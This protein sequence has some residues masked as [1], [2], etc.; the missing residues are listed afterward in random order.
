MNKLTFLELMRTPDKI[1]DVDFVELET[2]VKANPYFQNG[3]CVLA[4]A[5]RKLKKPS[6][7]KLMSSAAIYST[8][9]NIFKQYIQGQVK[10]EQAP[11]TKA[12]VPTSKPSPTPQPKAA[13]RKA[14]K[15]NSDEEQD[16][17]VKEIYE[18]LEKWKASREHYLDYDKKHPEEIVIED[19]FASSDARHTPAPPEEENAIS[20]PTPQEH[21]EPDM[22]ESEETPESKPEI[23]TTEVKPEVEVDEVEKLKNQVAEEIEAEEESISKALSEITE[24]EKKEDVSQ[25]AKD[26]QIEDTLPKEDAIAKPSGINLSSEELT[27]IV[28]AE[29]SMEPSETTDAPE[30]QSKEMDEV[31][32]IEQSV[33]DKLPTAEEI[34]EEVAKIEIEEEAASKEDSPVLSEEVEVH[35]DDTVASDLSAKEDQEEH[36][37]ED[38]V[39]IPIQIDVSSDKSTE[40]TEEELDQIGK[41]IQELKLTPGS[42]PTGKKF[43]LG[44]LK[45]GTKFTKEKVKKSPTSA[46]SK[47]TVTR[48]K[49]TKPEAKVET[50]KVAKPEAPKKTSTKSST[51]KS[52]TSKAT[53]TKASA[54][55]PEA[56]KTSTTKKTTTAKKT[57]ATK[58]TET[59]KAAPKKA[60]T[61]KATKK[62]AVRKEEAK[63]K[64][65]PSKKAT[66]KFRMSASIGAKTTKKTASKKAPK[67]DEDSSSEKKKPKKVKSEKKPDQLDIIDSFIEL[68]PSIQVSK[69]NPTDNQ[70]VEDLAAK[71]EVFPDDLVTENLANILIGQGKKEKAI[72]IYEKLILNNPQKKSYFASQI[73]KLKKK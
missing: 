21:D 5:G 14:P 29:S 17:L 46:T 36:K 26:P 52:T 43:R 39:E 45:R 20:V 15:L 38:E 42:S 59:K 48:A 70:P 25:E 67:K 62:T 27:A 28:D 71:Y 41:E 33:A 58:K 60:E 19:P 64:K 51:T 73:E 30:E 1:S 68:N 49:A 12:P 9:R 22:S 32:E 72:A 65:S 6:S 44:V 54:T 8:N 69:N 23:P 53:A 13:P 50:V 37:K 2:L 63:T 61:K 11:A 16:A 55:K 35:E 18:N 31:A 7:P 66:P 4:Y 57:A 10:F 40:E 24:K 56:S 3:R 47:K 34:E